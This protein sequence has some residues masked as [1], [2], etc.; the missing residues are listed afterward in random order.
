MYLAPLMPLFALIIA[1]AL[2]SFSGKWF[3]RYRK[4]WLALMSLILI[5]FAV[6]PLWSGFLPTRKIPPALMEWLSTWHL[7]A[8]LPI[9]AIVLM[10]IVERKP[11]PQWSK[12]AIITA[13][14]F[15]SAFNYLFPAIDIAKDMKPDLQAFVEQVPA[16]KRDRIASVR[17]S[18]TMTSIFF[19]YHDWAVPQV[20][21]ERA[22]AILDGVD[23][24]YDYLLLDRSNSTT[25]I[26]KFTPFREDT[27]YKILAKGTPRSD[28]EKDAVFWLS[29]Q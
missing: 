12:M 28:K 9:A 8:L 2:T 4:G 23:P 18:E 7:V 26:I 3:N 13:L 1:D 27:Q 6:V 25:D 15:S 19:L 16:E 10:V 24:D 11:W 14:F 5:A 29:G 20:S 21:V 22:Q 17:F